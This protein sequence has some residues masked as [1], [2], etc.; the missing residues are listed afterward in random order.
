MGSYAGVD[1]ASERHEVVVQDA[2]GGELL[3]ASFAHDEAGLQAL[4]RQLVRLEVELVAIERPDG[5]WSSGCSTPGSRCW[6]CTPTRWRR[7][8]RDSGHRAASPTGS[9]M[10]SCCASGAHRPPPLPGAGA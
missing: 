9:L 6:R 10:C 7:P 3:A 8:A 4:C 1:W 2:A 5:C